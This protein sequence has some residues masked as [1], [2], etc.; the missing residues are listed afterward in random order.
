MNHK[1]IAIAIEEYPSQTIEGSERDGPFR[2]T[3]V[4]VEGNIGDYAAYAG[5][6]DPEWVAHHGRKLLFGDAC[7][8]FYISQLQYRD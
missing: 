7:R 8:Y 2:I 4:L 3:I 1:I 6:G 5:H